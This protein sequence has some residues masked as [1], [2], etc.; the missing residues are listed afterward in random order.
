MMKH[1]DRENSPK[2]IPSKRKLRQISLDQV[3]VLAATSEPKGEIN[4]ISAEGDTD[5]LSTGAVD[6]TQEPSVA[7]TRISIKIVPVRGENTGSR[8]SGPGPRLAGRGSNPR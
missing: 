4:G 3:D 1:A 5:D 6:G 7:A 8:R 2:L